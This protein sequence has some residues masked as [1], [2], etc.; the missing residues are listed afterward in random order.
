MTDIIQSATVGQVGLAKSYKNTFWFGVGVSSL[1]LALM[2]IW[3]TIRKAT[4]ELTPE[5]KA[6]LIQAAEDESQ[7]SVVQSDRQESQTDP[8]VDRVQ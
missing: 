8:H 7:G 6:E 3:G 4:S 2:L 1:G 5:E